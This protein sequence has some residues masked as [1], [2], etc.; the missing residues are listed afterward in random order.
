MLVKEALYLGIKNRD[1][2][3]AYTEKTECVRSP[4]G[5]T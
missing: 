5:K 2:Y 1:N 4:H 3:T